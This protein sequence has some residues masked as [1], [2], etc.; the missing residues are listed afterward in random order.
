MKKNKAENDLITNFYE[1]VDA[2]ELPEI[3]LMTFPIAL[4]KRAFRPFKFR[5]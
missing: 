1:Q 5:G 2:K 4:I 3:F